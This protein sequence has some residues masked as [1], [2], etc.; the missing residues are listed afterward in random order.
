[1]LQGPNLYQAVIK[2][3]RRPPPETKVR[4]WLRTC[5]QGLAA[6]HAVG[7]VHRDIKPENLLLR[8]NTTLKIADLGLA[9]RVD[10]SAPWTEYVATRWYRAPEILLRSPT[11]GPAAD[12]YA[13]GAVA[14]ELYTLQPLF[15]GSSEVCVSCFLVCY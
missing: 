4:A 8:G 14:A 9:R 15:P 12:I 3:R 10:A 1:M 11:Y 13:L 6:L 2:D 7:Y 5:L